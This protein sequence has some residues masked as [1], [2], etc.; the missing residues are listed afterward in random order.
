MCKSRNEKN[1]IQFKALNTLIGVKNIILELNK[2]L[3]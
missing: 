2:F 1:Q 3:F